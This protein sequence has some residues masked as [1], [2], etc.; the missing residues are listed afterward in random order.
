VISA[1]IDGLDLGNAQVLVAQRDRAYFRD[2]D[3][4]VKRLPRGAEAG[5]QDISVSSDY[6][7]ATLR[8]TIGGAQAHGTA[9]LARTGTSWP[10]IVWRKYV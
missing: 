6:F 2:R 1:V 5:A 10:T 7:I 8:V 3:D 9:L 4:F